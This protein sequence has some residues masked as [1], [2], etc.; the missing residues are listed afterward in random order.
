MDAA[1][2]EILQIVAVLRVTSGFSEQC[3]QQY[4]GHKELTVFVISLFSLRN[5]SL[6]AEKKHLTFYNAEKMALKKIFYILI[7]ILRNC[8][9]SLKHVHR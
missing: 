6:F 9:L 8:E 7:M 4:V 5:R 2:V 1:A 3:K